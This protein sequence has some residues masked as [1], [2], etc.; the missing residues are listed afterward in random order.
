M[1]SIARCLIGTLLAC[2]TPSAV[3]AAG[4]A[5]AQASADGKRLTLGAAYVPP[6]DAPDGRI[7][8]EEGFEPDLARL[9][10]ETLGIP[11]R[12]VVVLDGAAASETG[13]VDGV[14]VRLKPD[15]SRLASGDAV[16]LGYRSGLSVAMRSDTT[17]RRWEDL[18]GRT[19]CAS[20]ANVSGQRI[21]RS[22]GAKV[23]VVRAP[24]PALMRVR[25]GEC[26][27]AIHDRVLLDELFTSRAWTKFSATLPPVEPTVL[28]IVPAPTGTGAALRRAASAVSGSGAWRERRVR[29]A[30]T[31]AFEVYRDQV[32]GDCH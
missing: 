23:A 13:S 5:G 20:E 12:L 15:D 30:S 22:F 1:T 6:P 26:D 31:V 19:V 27:A 7:Y 17:I 28:A 25:S 18:A 2:L 9:L 29:W 16:P 3:S 4:P 32:A 10:G 11:V 21:A 14:F 8:Y 24:A